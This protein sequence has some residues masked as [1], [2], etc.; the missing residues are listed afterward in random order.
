MTREISE[1][2][3]SLVRADSPAEVASRAVVATDQLA[4]HFG[5]LIGEIGVRTLLARSARLASVRF[6]WLANT[7]S[8]EPHADAPWTE[9][10]GVLALRDPQTAIDAFAELVTTFIGLLSK[11][12]GEALVAR[13]LHEVWP[14]PFPHVVKES[15]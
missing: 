1:A 6:P 12:I 8:R 4:Q 13:L 2:V 9:L 3:R 5:R 15:T 11:M 7:I 14:E 10:G